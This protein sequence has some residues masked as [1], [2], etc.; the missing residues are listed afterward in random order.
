[1]SRR[2]R[3]LAAVLATFAFVFAQAATAAYACA[4]PVDMG[5]DGGL[6]EKHCATGTVSLDV[7][8]P[9]L[10]AMATVVAVPIRV[11]FVAPAP[12]RISTRAT[13]LSVAGPEPPL[14]RF[15][16]LRI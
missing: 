7:A 2:F 9:S 6:C 11:A 14:I 5:H 15:T 16:V 8:K 3:M 10:P 13:D 4:G 1:M 12:L